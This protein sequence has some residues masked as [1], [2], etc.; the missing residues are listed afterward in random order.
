MTEKIRLED[1]VWTS[2][3]KEVY[4]RIAYN[5]QFV[6]QSLFELSRWGDGITVNDP[7]G[8]AIL[9]EHVMPAIESLIQAA[10]GFESLANSIEKEI[11]NAKL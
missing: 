6:C 9:N 5:L 1:I 4:K 7:L 8:M 10:E 3:R 11:G 2:A